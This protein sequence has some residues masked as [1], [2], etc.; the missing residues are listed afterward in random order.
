MWGKSGIT[1]RKQWREDPHSSVKST[2]Q[3][4]SLLRAIS[5]QKL[6][7]LQTHLVGQLV[8]GLNAGIAVMCSSSGLHWTGAVPGNQELIQLYV[9]CR[10]CTICQ[11]KLPVLLC[12]F[13]TTLSVQLSVQGLCTSCPRPTTLSHQWSKYPCHC[14]P[15]L[16][17]INGPN[18][19]VTAPPPTLS[20]QW[21]KYPCHCHPPLYR[22]NGPNILVTAPPPTLSHQWSKY[23]CHCPPPL[24]HINGPI[25]LSLL[26]LRNLPC[27]QNYI[28]E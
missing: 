6:M 12:L 18:I 17:H 26:S 27:W 4:E 25:S 13:S 28:V 9:Y 16:Y 19:L 14:H 24:Y 5:A 22:I 11:Y 2:Q 7:Q 21:S 10:T 23:P 1:I 3:F 20:H 15:P 8:E